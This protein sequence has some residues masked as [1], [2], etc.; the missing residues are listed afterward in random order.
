MANV[1]FGS[2]PACVK[3]NTKKH[4]ISIVLSGQTP[5]FYISTLNS[6]LH[7]AFWDDLFLLSVCINKNQ[8]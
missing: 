2:K 4:T 1:A 6:L 8:S 3:Q 7:Q 5:Y